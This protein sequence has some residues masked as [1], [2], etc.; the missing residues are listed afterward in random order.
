MRK[1]GH[2][3]QPRIGIKKS[4]NNCEHC[5]QYI[6]KG[7]IKGFL[8]SRFCSRCWQFRE[9]KGGFYEMTAENREKFVDIFRFYEK[10]EGIH[11]LKNREQIEHELDQAVHIMTELITKHKNNDLV[12]NLLIACYMDASRKLKD[13]K[14]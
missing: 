1:Y 14:I 3:F 5:E 7:F 6:K 10:I 8:C 4:V 9:Q 11:L 13:T 12:K 2:M